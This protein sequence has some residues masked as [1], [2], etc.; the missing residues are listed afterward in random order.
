MLWSITC[1]NVMTARPA[2][3]FLFEHECC[4]AA[5]GDTHLSRDQMFFSG[6]NVPGLFPLIAND[7][8]T[9]ERTRLKLV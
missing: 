7:Y 6:Y 3:R 1:L 9:L 4:L 8:C 2:S 5:E